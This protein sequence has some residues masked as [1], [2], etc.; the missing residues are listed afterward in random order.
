MHLKCQGPRLGLNRSRGVN[1]LMRAYFAESLQGHISCV[2]NEVP[3]V[4]K[5]SISRY[6]KANDTQG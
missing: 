4:K 2:T 3:T 5:I 6:V 1:R